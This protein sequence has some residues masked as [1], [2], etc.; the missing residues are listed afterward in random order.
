MAL[1]ARCPVIPV[2][3]F[4][5]RELQPIGKKMPK[6]SGRVEVQFG[7]P[8]SFAWATPSDVAIYGRNF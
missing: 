6:L 4:G 7:K 8:L 3:A 5:T 1:L 2:A